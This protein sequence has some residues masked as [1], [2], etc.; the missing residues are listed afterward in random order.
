V[1]RASDHAC[2]AV[3]SEDCTAKY[4]PGDLD[5]DDTVWLGAMLPTKGPHAAEYGAMN[6]DGIDFARKEIADATSVLG[7]A[8]ATAPRR[9]RRIALV[10]CDDSAEPL[11][12]AGHL[13]EDVGVPAVL[14]FGTGGELVEVAEK[15]LFPHDV[16]AVA[17]LTSNPTVTALQQPSADARL[18][19]RTTYSFGTL[20]EGTAR[21]VSEVLEP[22]LAPRG[23]ARVVVLRDDNVS[24]LAFADTFYRK[25]VLNGKA[26]VDDEHDYV[27]IVLKGSA[28]AD[29]AT[30]IDRVVAA[31]PTIVVFLA[32]AAA[33]QPLIQG[34]EARARTSAAARPTYVL[35]NDGTAG[36]APLLVSD[37]LR[38]RVLA[39]LSPSNSAPNAR[40][41]IRYNQAR[42]V[43]VTRMNNPSP[44]YDAFYLVA[45]GIFALGPGEAVTGSAIARGFARLVP[46][47][48][49]LEV[50]PTNV[51]EAFAILGGGG[52]FD[53]EGAASGL[54]FDLATGEAPSDFT[55]L[56]AAPAK[57]GKPSGQDAETGAV[58]RAK[59]GRTEG[60][61]Q[62][63]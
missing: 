5:A 40:F 63:P 30:A 4:E 50:G 38:R 21:L 58:Y 57:N 31:R 13:V 14:G 36:V 49:A 23:T 18:V 19:W 53:L 45:Y 51:L 3:E 27:E 37:D 17:S 61:F 7:G 29:V 28:P 10:A 41:V 20:A 26:A 1:C 32:D 46:P 34:V 24:A 54:D 43:P 55:L 11:R 59:T 35:V 44:S 56:C 48:K 8:S 33:E 12:A 9:V 22:R 42:A 15:L 39:V 62:C 16:L 52:R 6:M 60:T 2:V 25:L 47:G